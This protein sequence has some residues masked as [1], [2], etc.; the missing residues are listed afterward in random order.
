VPESRLGQL[1]DITGIDPRW[2]PVGTT[3][4]GVLAGYTLTLEKARPT[5]A[6]D[7]RSALVV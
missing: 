2:S 4:R 1:V 7:L 3:Y 5:V 6:L